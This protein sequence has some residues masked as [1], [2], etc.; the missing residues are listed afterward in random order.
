[1]SLSDLQNLFGFLSFVADLSK[2]PVFPPALPLGG[3]ETFC[4]MFGSKE[5]SERGNSLENSRVCRSVL[6]RP[7]EQRG[8]RK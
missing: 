1:V 5:A 7:G 4:S 3:G 6:K 2:P 8:E